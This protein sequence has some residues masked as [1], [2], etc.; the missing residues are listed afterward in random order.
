MKYFSA[1]NSYWESSDRQK[2]DSNVHNNVRRT[3]RTCVRLH[4]SKSELISI[5]AE[6]QTMPSKKIKFSAM[7]SAVANHPVCIVDS[8][9]SVSFESSNWSR[10]Q[11]HENDALPH[12]ICMSCACSIRSAYFFKCQAENSYRQLHA[13][14]TRVIEAQPITIKQEKVDDVAMEGVQEGRPDVPLILEP[15]TLDSDATFSEELLLE[16]ET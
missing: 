9:T 14:L 8:K 5:F 2:M 4:D 15:R 1:I 3:C 11:V 10:Q 7:L 13:Q 16:L 12:R 6:D